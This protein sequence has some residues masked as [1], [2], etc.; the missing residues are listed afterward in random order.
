M[1][2]PDDLPV[3]VWRCLGEASGVF[4]RLFNTILERMPGADFQ[5]QR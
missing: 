1:V 3:E 2:G 5:E 4:T